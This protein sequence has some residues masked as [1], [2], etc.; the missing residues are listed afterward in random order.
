M[1]DVVKGKNVG[2]GLVNTT[3][4]SP[5][6]QPQNFTALLFL[7]CRSTRKKTKFPDA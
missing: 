6:E 5:C 1:D 4:V 2:G 7:A 3:V